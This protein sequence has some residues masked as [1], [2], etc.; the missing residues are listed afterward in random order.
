M[1][2]SVADYKRYVLPIIFLRFLSLRYEERRAELER[3]LD[4][5]SSDYHTTN[6][7]DREAV[8]EDPDE[9]RARGAF[10][11]PPEARWE[12]ILEAARRDDLKSH[13]D[14][15]LQALEEKNS[16]SIPFSRSIFGLASQARGSRGAGD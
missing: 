12:A 6:A 8:L 2:L 1:A 7:T 10:V 4:D 9:Y 11:V 15:V 5:P 3:L 13:L 14:E 16:V